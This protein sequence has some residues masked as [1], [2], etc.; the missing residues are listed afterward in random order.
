VS[1]ELLE[2]AATHLEP[3]LDRLAFLG[4][5][6]MVLWISD[7]S[8]P[9]VRPTDDVDVIVE[10]GSYVAYQQLG[11]ELRRL[12]FAEDPASPL[13]CRWRHRSGV[14]VDV[15]PTDPNVLGFANRWYPSALAAATPVRLPSGAEIRAV[16]PPHLLAT[17]LEAF[18]SRGAGDYLGSRDFGDIVTL[19]DGRSELVDEVRGADEDV[20]VYVAEAFE[21]MKDD[22]FFES[23]VAG[24]LLP[25][26]A[27]QARRGLVLERIQALIEAGGG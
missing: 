16:P 17:K 4:G 2:V 1:Y 20:R 6:A 24:A 18:R 10:V 23:G 7:P 22:V 3:V 15:M 21:S 11:E 27:S 25:D 26:A 14:D 19:V 13:L 12:G 9:P 8:A 5:A